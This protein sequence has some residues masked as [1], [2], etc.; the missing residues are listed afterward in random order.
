[1]NATTAQ[2]KQILKRVLLL[3]LALFATMGIAGWASDS[4][5]L[6]A[7]ALGSISNLTIYLLSVLA[8]DQ[9]KAW[10]RR[11]AALSG[12]AL[13]ILAAAIIAD[14]LRRVFFG[15]EPVGLIMMLCAL[16]AATV[17]YWCMKQLQN[18][19]SEEINVRAAT[20][21]S[22]Y[23]F[24]STSGLFIAGGLVVLLQSPWPDLLLSTLVA[25][26]AMNR[27]IETIAS[28]AEERTSPVAS[29]SRRGAR[30]REN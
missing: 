5:A 17:N 18:L 15:T 28:L 3:N 21:F 25:A 14:A 29:S 19:H 4:S 12:M 20:S 30:E 10:K 22:Y 27:G 23:D 9:R 8:I 1:M 13:L 2:Q 24:A 6:I 26:V 11:V 16:A 7:N